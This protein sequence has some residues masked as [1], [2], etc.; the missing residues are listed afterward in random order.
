LPSVVIVTNGE[1]EM[2]FPPVDENNKVKKVL[3]LDY[4]ILLKYFDLE[5]RYL[6]TREF[7]GERE[8]GK[9]KGQ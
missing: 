8:E 9:L 5:S 2:R 1:E 3:K 6:E 4:R 7:L